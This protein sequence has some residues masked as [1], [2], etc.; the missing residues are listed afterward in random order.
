MVVIRGRVIK[1]KGGYG[2]ASHSSEVAAYFQNTPVRGTLNIALD[3][4]VRLRHAK[5]LISMIWPSYIGGIP[6]LITRTS[7]TP[8]H[9]V[10]VISDEQLPCTRGDRVTLVIPRG[11]T[12]D[13][14]PIHHT[15]WKVFY[16]YGRTHWYEYKIY[17]RL[18][19]PFY[20]V[21][22]LSIQDPKRPD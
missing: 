3:Q 15:I 2:K 12:V 17:R 4:P 18:L 13:L 11:C 9:I 21:R 8:L 6:C 7:H 19:G 20:F 5:A 14:P 16:G 1:G 10:E 22:R